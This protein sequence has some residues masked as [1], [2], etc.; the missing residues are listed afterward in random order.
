MTDRNLSRRQFMQLSAVA[1]TTALLAACA[2]PGAAPSDGAG[3]SP[4]E[5]GITL[6]Y[7][8]RELQEAEGIVELWDEFYPQFQE[9]NDGIAVEFLPQ[10]A[11]QNLRENVLTQM[12]A[13]D[14]PDLAEFC[15]WS[16]TFF[17]QKG[18]TLN[19]Q[20]FIDR[21]AEEVN[22]DDYYDGQFDPWLDDSGNIHLM[23]RFT[24][25][26]CLYY[27]IEMFE[28]AGVETPP[29]EWGAWTIQDYV[30]MGRNFVSREQPIS[31]ATSNYG[32]S[33]NWLSQYWIRGFGANMVDPED[34]T[35]CGLCDPEAQEAL[36]WMRSII[37][38]EQVFAYGSDIGMGVNQLFES[39]RIAMMEMGP[40][41]LGQ[42]AKNASFKWDVAP[43]PDGPAGTTTHQS[44]DGTMVWNK[45]EHP[46]ESW[47]LLKWLT[48]PMYGR[49]YSK[50]ATKQPSRKSI[51]DQFHSDLIERDASFADI[52]INVFTSSIAADLGGPEEMFKEDFVCKD[53]I[54]RPAFE[55]VMLLGEQPVDLIC[56]HADIATSYNRGEIPL[57]D[58]GAAMDAA[59]S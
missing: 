37:W 42:T 45:T 13:G 6:R 25:T 22:M 1:G 35:R 12:V 15:C 49:L 4:G 36:E 44:V 46:E 39:G 2:V 10:P 53:T 32:L 16:S 51:L 24:G 59:S 26:M 40:W 38:D 5:E 48:S 20:P 3:A 55:Q 29:H 56:R 33:S 52:D 34:N 50:W 8:S 27:N 57:E 47:E 21:D 31:W 43:L 23:P 11:G 41:S 58:L 7:Q 19:L 30:E 54:L 28:E 18:E 17:I 9:E 14:A